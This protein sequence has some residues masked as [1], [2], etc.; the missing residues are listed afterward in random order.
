MPEPANVTIQIDLLQVEAS[1]RLDGPRLRQAVE[2]ELGR[3]IQQR[4]LSDALPAARPAVTVEAD[5]T[6]PVAAGNDAVAV[7]IADAIYRGLTG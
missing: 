3:L 2:R 6:G 7:E 4:G 1:Q 5:W